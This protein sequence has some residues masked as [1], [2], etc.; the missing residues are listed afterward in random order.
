MP[1][2]A[3]TVIAEPQSENTEKKLF[4]FTVVYARDSTSITSYLV[5]ATNYEEAE[6]EVKDYDREGGEWTEWY[7]VTGVEITSALFQVGS[8]T[9]TITSVFSWSR[10]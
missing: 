6:E 9:T 3:L 10:G 8:F 1:K 4:L 5:Q 7:E 2:E